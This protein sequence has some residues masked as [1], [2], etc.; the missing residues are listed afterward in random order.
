MVT[1]ADTPRNP[2]KIV[3]KADE[4]MYYSK[5]HGKNRITSENCIS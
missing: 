1:Y 4:L 3:S 2:G 5:K